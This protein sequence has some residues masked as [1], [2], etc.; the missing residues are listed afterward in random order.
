MKKES[1]A[2][3]CRMYEFTGA[4]LPEGHEFPTE[5]ILYQ[6]LK[7]NDFNRL[8]N[9]TVLAFSPKQDYRFENGKTRH[10]YFRDDI[11]TNRYV[12][13][14]VGERVRG[15]NFTLISVP[16]LR[17]EVKI[18]SA[19]FLWVTGRTATTHSLL[20][21]CANIVLAARI[22]ESLGYTSL[23]KLSVPFIRNAFIAKIRAPDDKGRIRSERT[24]RNYFLDLSDLALLGHTRLREMGYSLD[25]MFNDYFGEN[26]SNQ[27]YCIPF[28]LM[29]KIWD[30]LVSEL[31]AEINDFNY[32]DLSRIVAI[33]NGYFDSSYYVSAKKNNHG[34]STAVRG[35]YRTAYY[36][37]TVQSDIKLLH[38]S[39]NPRMRDWFV[40]AS[41]KRWA[42]DFVG[43]DNRKLQAWH[44]GLTQKIMVAIQ[45]MSGMRQTEALGVMHG[46]LIYDGDVIGLKSILQKFAPEGGQHEDWVVC[47]YI[48]KPFLHLRRVN[49]ILTGLPYDELDLLPVS[50]N[51]RSWMARRKIT[52]MAAQR[53]SEWSRDFVNRHHLTVTEDDIHEFR[54]LNPNIRDSVRAGKDISLGA[55]W[56]LRTH[57]FRRSLAVHLRRLDLI[58]TSDLIRQFKHFAWSMTEWYMSGAVGATHFSRTVPADFAAELER[59]ELELSAS[60]AVAFQ[61]EGKLAG[62]GGRLLMSQRQSHPHLMTF[63]DLKKAMSM[64]RRGGHK[65]VSLGNGFYCMNGNE[66]E[67]RSVIQSSSC[68]PSCP[69]MLA[70]E[71]SLPVWKR[72]LA[73]YN[74]LLDLA[75]QN[76]ASQADRDF[77]CLERDFYVNAIC[78]FEEENT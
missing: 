12:R 61:Y 62:E 38:N 4:P 40:V 30:G 21:K 35:D 70:G 26:D 14:S 73:H 48:E 47:R 24:L 53:Q 68:N 52:F 17:F 78:F 44:S 72:R 5:D 3:R 39:I 42:H 34:K 36:Y 27:T 69:N 63:P 16:A 1:V 66:C 18:I 60:R 59:T 25:V 15:V 31:D 76:N 46:S 77:L 50:L 10:I 71:D 19:C 55:Y 20:R 41:N 75:I 65:L 58:S 56:P 29:I 7:S 45:A 74:R 67:F 33:N 23:F 43:I 13:T 54:L 49:Q 37:N 6:A 11:W 8:N 2:Q 51:I 64:A 32:D 28:R 9:C 57:Q 22:I